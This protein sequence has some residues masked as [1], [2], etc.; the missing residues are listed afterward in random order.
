MRRRMES[1]P[2]TSRF[3][4]EAAVCRL[5]MEFSAFRAWRPQAQSSPRSGYLHLGLCA[6]DA[7]DDGGG[8]DDDGGGEDGEARD[9][10]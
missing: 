5:P 6:D 9:E 2:R 7:C 8:G 3:G 4:S 10:T 1:E